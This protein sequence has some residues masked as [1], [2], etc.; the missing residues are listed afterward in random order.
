MLKEWA[1]FDF[2]SCFRHMKQTTPVN[3]NLQKI[4]I[5]AKDKI[6]YIYRAITLTVPVLFDIELHSLIGLL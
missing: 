3:N 2:K 4:G 6:I 5:Y 1:V